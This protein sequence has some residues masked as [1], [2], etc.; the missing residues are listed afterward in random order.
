MYTFYSLPKYFDVQIFFSNKMYINDYALDR[1]FFP[2]GSFG[3]NPSTPTSEIVKA[4][5]PSPPASGGR[6]G[7][8]ALAPRGPLPW[9][10]LCTHFPPCLPPPLG[11]L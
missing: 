7:E 11:S 4:A 2:L 8:R 9:S 3:K 5:T 10:L 6:G 1:H